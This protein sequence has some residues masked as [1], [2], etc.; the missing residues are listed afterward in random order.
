MMVPIVNSDV[1]GLTNY[2][3]HG[4][5]WEANTLSASQENTHIP[6]FVIMSTKAFHM[7]LS[8]AR[9][10]QS[11]PPHPI[12]LRLTPFAQV[13]P[14]KPCMHISAKCATSPTHLIL[15][16]FITQIIIGEEYKLW[17]STLWNF[18]RSSVP[19]LS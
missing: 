17:S 6:W 14:P 12:S 13:S 18:L 8:Q 16:D 15:L 4:T 5:S 11:V 7:P 10:I 9:T 1:M 3:Q 19:P 2:T